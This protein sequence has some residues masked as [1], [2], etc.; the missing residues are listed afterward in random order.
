MGSV[1]IDQWLR[2]KANTY[3]VCKSMETKQCKLIAW[4]I[5]S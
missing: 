1:F 4:I 3:F 2:T 5:S